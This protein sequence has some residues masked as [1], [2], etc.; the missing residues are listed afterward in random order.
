MS[1][2]VIKKEKIMLNLLLKLNP[3]E[4]SFT[5]L[6]TDLVC[7][8]IP[9]KIKIKSF[10]QGAALSRVFFLSFFLSFSNFLIINE[11]I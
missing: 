3:I 8:F 2:N 7:V 4:I 10:L 5:I 9:I 11:L 6:Q 1:L